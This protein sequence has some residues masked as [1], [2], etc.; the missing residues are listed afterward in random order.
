MVYHKE[1]A[2]V[3]SYHGEEEEKRKD[4]EADSTTRL[5]SHSYSNVKTDVSHKHLII[6]NIQPNIPK[7]LHLNP[8]D[9]T[10]LRCLENWTEIDA[11]AP[12]SRH[13]DRTSRPMSTCSERCSH[14]PSEGSDERILRL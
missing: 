9:K 2:V 10:S 7:P 6:F 1:G 3:L 8:F 13:R 5:Y 11:Q 12:H 4:E 14:D